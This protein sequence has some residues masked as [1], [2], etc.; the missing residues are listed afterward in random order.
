MTHV[1]KAF[2][3]TPK[4]LLHV[5]QQLPAR[6]ALTQTST[7]KVESGEVFTVSFP[8][9]TVFKLLHFKRMSPKT[10]IK[11]VPLDNSAACGSAAEFDP[12]TD[13]SRR[14][15]LRPTQTPAAQPPARSAAPVTHRHVSPPKFASVSPKCYKVVQS[16]LQKKNPAFL[17]PLPETSKSSRSGSSMEGAEAKEEG[18]GKV[19]RATWNWE[20]SDTLWTLCVNTWWLFWHDDERGL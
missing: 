18:K 15:T 17:L 9:F 19:S 7:Q 12:L 5:C 14:K 3:F 16:F 11:T 8:T 10:V 2:V 13:S 1:K 6:H 4:L 20:N